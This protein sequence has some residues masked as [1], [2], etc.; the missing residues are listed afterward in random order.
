MMNM[1]PR[2]KEHEGITTDMRIIETEHHQLSHSHHSQL[3][4]PQL[5]STK[6]YFVNWMIS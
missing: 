6:L 1:T 5:I 4:P 2:V 3:T